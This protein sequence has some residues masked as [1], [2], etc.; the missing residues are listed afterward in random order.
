MRIL[1]H[2]KKIAFLILI[3]LLSVLFYLNRG[4]FIK[5]KVA[6]ENLEIAGGNYSGTGYYSV[7]TLNNKKGQDVNFWIQNTGKNNIKISI[8]DKEE[9]VLEP[10]KQGHISKQLGYWSKEYVFK[11]TS[12]KDG[13]RIN[14]EYNISGK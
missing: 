2:K 9:R 8:N 13:R 11:A 7:W 12:E 4:F 3:I 14:M 6:V 10:G 1:K 5:D